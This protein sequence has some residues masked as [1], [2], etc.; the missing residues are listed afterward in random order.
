M[1]DLDVN[2]LMAERDRLK[3]IVDEAKTAKSKLDYL[4][5]LIVLYY[6]DAL[7]DEAEP[8]VDVDAQD[9]QLDEDEGEG[10]YRCL[11][12]DPP[13]SFSTPNGL[14]IHSGRLHAF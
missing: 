7:K 13:R 12:C 3:E 11:A 5:K 4:E 2:V 10:Q 14:A 8:E 6:P 1:S 9:V